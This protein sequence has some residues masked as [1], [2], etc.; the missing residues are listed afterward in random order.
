[1]NNIVVPISV[2]NGVEPPFEAVSSSQ[3]IRGW[4]W[5]LYCRWCAFGA[6]PL[7]WWWSKWT[8]TT[9]GCEPTKWWLAATN[10]Y[11]DCYV[12]QV[13]QVVS[14]AYRWKALFKRFPMV[15]V[16]ITLRGF[17]QKLF[18]GFLRNP[19]IFTYGCLHSIRTIKREKIMPW[20]LTSNIG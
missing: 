1:M 4:H 17:V 15:P 8:T 10:F 6:P 13:P 5:C 20:R 14:M 9:M 12:L 3:S 11:V 2:D 18:Y 7:A 16:R 19:P